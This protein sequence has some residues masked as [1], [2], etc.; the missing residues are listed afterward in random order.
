[1]SSPPAMSHA[2]RIDVTLEELRL[3]HRNSYMT[4]QFR[5]NQHSSVPL[6]GA[7]IQQVVVRV[8]AILKS[9]FVAS[10][11]DVIQP[12]RITQD[13][14]HRSV[15]SRVVAQVTKNSDKFSSINVLMSYTCC[16]SDR[17]KRIPFNSIEGRKIIPLPLV[18]WDKIFGMVVH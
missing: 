13:F 5:R 10:S 4:N 11:A 2:C 3:C 7:N 17:T 1:M 16:Q 14:A 9:G 8:C 6:D 15:L 18:D 12:L